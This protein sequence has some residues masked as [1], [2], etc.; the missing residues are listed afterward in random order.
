MRGPRKTCGPTGAKGTTI[1][2]GILI[3]ALYDGGQKTSDFTRLAIEILGRTQISKPM[4]F[5]S[6]PLSNKKSRLPG[7]LLKNSSK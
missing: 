7:R 1:P 4:Y 6:N 3:T 2:G 5:F